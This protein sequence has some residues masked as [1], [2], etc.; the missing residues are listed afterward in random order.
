MH[1][2]LK[3][4]AEGVEL[5]TVQRGFCGQQADLIDDASASVA[6]QA[7]HELN[8]CPI[9]RVGNAFWY[10]GRV[11]DEHGLRRITLADEALHKAHAAELLGQLRVSE[12]R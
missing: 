5:R 2:V 3:R 12:R 6:R 11:P 7:L 9:D 4:I 1:R 10:T 8:L